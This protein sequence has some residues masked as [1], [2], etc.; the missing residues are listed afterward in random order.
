M[1][2]GRGGWKSEPGASWMG[3][4]PVFMMIPFFGVTISIGR[5][6]ENSRKR[7]AVTLHPRKQSCPGYGQGGQGVWRSTVQCLCSFGGKAR[8][9]DVL[10]SGR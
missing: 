9:R 6:N 7:P 1:G 5:L 2:S 3:G 10:E 8:I 4:Y